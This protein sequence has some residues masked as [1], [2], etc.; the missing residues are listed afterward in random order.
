MI[1]AQN[2]ADEACH[3]ELQSQSQYLGMKIYT[4][5]LGRLCIIGV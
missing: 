3:R 4:S 5:S 2:I 1:M